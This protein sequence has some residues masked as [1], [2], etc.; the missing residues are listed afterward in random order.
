MLLTIYGFT[1]KNNAFCSDLVFVKQEFPHFNRIYIF[2]V[3]QD[4]IKLK[5]R[6]W[7][8]MRMQVLILFKT[9]RQVFI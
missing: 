5:V 2:T 7:G 1:E 6:Q 8:V 4:I 9:C 3:Y